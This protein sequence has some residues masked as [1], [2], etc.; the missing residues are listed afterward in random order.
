MR[1]ILYASIGVLVLALLLQGIAN[2]GAWVLHRAERYEDEISWLQVVGPFLPWERGM[3]RRID[4]LQSEIVRRELAD[5][6][7]EQAMK[8]LRRA[9][10]RLKSRG[11]RPDREMMAIGIETYTRAS[12]HVEK[13]GKLSAAADWNDSLFIFAIRAE[14]PQHRYAALSAFQEGLD[15]RVRDGKP[16]VALA[17]V[18]W[19]KAGLGGVVPGLQSNVEEDLQIQCEQSKRRGSRR[20]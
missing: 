7:L 1:Y 17:H 16:C 15:L 12:D 11:V 9:R 14:Q 19:A 2:T 20:R 10:A 3:Q 5:G 13:L 18:A 6:Q 4:A 8:A